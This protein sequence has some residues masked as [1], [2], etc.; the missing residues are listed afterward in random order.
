[1][2][3][4]R[5]LAAYRWLF[6]VLLLIG[7]AQALWRHGAEHAHATLLGLAEACGALLLVP[8]TQW[9][10]AWLLLLVFSC[11]QTVAARASEWPVRFALYAAGAFLI[12]L[13]DR[14]LRRQ[15]GR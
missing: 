2:S 8:R 12:V 15:A 9:L 13:L 7:S 14:A 5:I 3:A 1:M 4:P 10:G 6:C 11:A